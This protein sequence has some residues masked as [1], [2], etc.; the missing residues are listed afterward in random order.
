MKLWPFTEAYCAKTTEWFLYDLYERVL[1]ILSTRHYIL[2]F[3]AAWEPIDLRE[4]CIQGNIDMAVYR[5]ASY[6][7]R[8][9]FN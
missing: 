5:Q 1:C 6:S 9:L 2:R 7:N 4:V 3:V 8:S